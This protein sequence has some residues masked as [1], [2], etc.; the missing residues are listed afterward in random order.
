MEQEVAD[1]ITQ[2]IAN[3]AK[4]NALKLHEG[5]NSITKELTRV[6]KNIEVRHN[7]PAGL[8]RTTAALA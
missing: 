6:P 8:S 4:Q 7:Y 2:L 5:Y 1:R 3:V